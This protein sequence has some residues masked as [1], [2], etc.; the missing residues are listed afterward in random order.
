MA[1]FAE[2]DGNNVVIRVLVVPDSEQSRGQ[3]YL[4]EDLLLGGTWIQCSYNGNIRKQYPGPGYRYDYE[5]DVFISPS[6]FKSWALNSNNDWAPPCEKP[7][8]GKLYQWNEDTVSWVQIS[9]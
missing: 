8:D 9:D 1:H 4:A 5:K 3:A 7:N 2:L 6:P